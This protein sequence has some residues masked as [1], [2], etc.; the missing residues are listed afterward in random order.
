VVDAQVLRCGGQRSF[1]GH[2]KEESHVIPLKFLHVRWRST[3]DRLGLRNPA[4]EVDYGPEPEP[5]KG[6]KSAASGASA[7]RARP[8]PDPGW[9]RLHIPWAGLAM[10]LMKEN[11]EQ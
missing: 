2:G 8:W 11:I 5:I 9:P 6:M 3:L 7:S 10:A 1:S 4:V